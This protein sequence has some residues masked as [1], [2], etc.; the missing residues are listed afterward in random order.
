[1]KDIGNV[2]IADICSP[3]QCPLWPQ[4]AVRPQER[5]WT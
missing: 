4:T 2:D 5:P 1:M 3:K